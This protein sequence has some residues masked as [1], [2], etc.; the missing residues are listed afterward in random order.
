[1]DLVWFLF[2]VAVGVA[3]MYAICD[4]ALATTDRDE[5]YGL[6]GWHRPSRRVRRRTAATGL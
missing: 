5:L 4:L 2:G 3:L 6:L 1:M